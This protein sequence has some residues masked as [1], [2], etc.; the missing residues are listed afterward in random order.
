MLQDMIGS[1]SQINSINHQLI[2][3]QLIWNS[4]GR[5][6]NGH[7]HHLVIFLLG[8]RLPLLHQHMGQVLA[9]Y[10]ALIV[11]IQNLKCLEQL[12]RG[13]RLHFVL[14]QDLLKVRQELGHVHD[15]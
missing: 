3:E 4:V 15:T 10:E 7:G 13:C 9:R 6:I 8:E 12:L 1:P 14:Q 11:G 2:D 5:G